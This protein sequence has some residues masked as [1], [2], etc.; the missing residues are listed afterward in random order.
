MEDEVVEPEAFEQ[1]GPDLFG[2]EEPPRPVMPPDEAFPRIR[3]IRV[4][5]TVL[6][7]PTSPTVWRPT[8]TRVTSTMPTPSNGFR[9]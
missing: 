1:D 2:D 9:S 3:V 4:C 5:W 6:R 7:L 8:R